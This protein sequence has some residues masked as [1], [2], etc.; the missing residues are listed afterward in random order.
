LHRPIILRQSVDEDLQKI[1]EM[2]ESYDEKAFYQGLP[3]ADPKK[4][5]EWVRYVMAEGFNI[6]GL[7][8]NNKVI[9]HGSIFA[10]DKRRAE[11]LVAIR[12][13][14]QNAGIGQTLSRTI[15]TAA[16]ELGFSQMW[17]VV[18]TYNPKARH[19]YTKLGFRT[20]YSKV[21][22][23]AEMVIDLD[24]DP[25]IEVTISQIMTRDVCSVNSEKCAIDAINLFIEKDISGVP[26]V[27]SNNRLVGFITETDVLES[28]VKDRRI[29]EIMTRDI[30]YV[31]ENTKIKDIVNLI[32]ESRVKQIPVVDGDHRQLVGII[33]RKDIIRHLF[34][35]DEGG[36]I[37]AQD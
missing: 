4:L 22:E 27:D 26:V 17:L 36:N 9:C 13:D 11:F 24:F 2:Y 21:G 8:F 30:I 14:F 25:A 1:I 32:C 31:N 33:S 6:T 15:K 18:E 12:Q 19:I 28:W 20:T 34:E 16:K 7:S 37:A 23:E 3:P 35:N 29:A 10:I 5:E